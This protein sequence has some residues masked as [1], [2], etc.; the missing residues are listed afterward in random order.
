MADTS[1]TSNNAVPT[2]HDFSQWKDGRISRNLFYTSLVTRGRTVMDPD[3]KSPRTSWPRV[4]NFIIGLGLGLGL[5]HL[6]S[7]CPWTFYLA[8]W[9]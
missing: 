8:S 4:Q 3:V 6:S 9:K 2:T 1:L 7:A 5:K